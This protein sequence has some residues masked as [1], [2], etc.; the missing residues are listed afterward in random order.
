[1]AIN[2]KKS[3]I[4]RSIF[5]NS[6]SQ[7]MDTDYQNIL[8]N[9]TF[10]YT[11]IRNLFQESGGDFSKKSN[12]KGIQ[13][14]YGDLLINKIRYPFYV[15]YLKNSGEPKNSNKRVQ[16]YSSIPNFYKDSDYYGL[17]IYPTGDDEVI[18]LN[19]FTKFAINKINQ[20]SKNFSSLWINFENISKSY[21][22][23][24][25]VKQEDEDK[26]SYIFRKSNFNHFDTALKM[27]LELNNPISTTSAEE[28]QSPPE[29]ILVN[30]EKLPRNPLLREKVIKLANYTC[31]LCLK[32]DTFKTKDREFY[33]E[34]HHLIP[35]NVTNQKLFKYSLDHLSNLVCLCPECHRKVHFSELKEQ[36][37]ALT[38]LIK[39]RP[40]LSKI[41]NVKSDKELILF[42]DSR[43][44][45]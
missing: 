2:S 6:I 26:V 42:Y 41:Y 20:K 10:R 44:S 43:E 7:L 28:L 15:S 21:F 39:K 25:I 34:A 19:K 23:K 38:H 9:F 14:F 35:F 11:E 18:A 36:I 17:A 22:K 12:L 1:M 3:K 4:Y 8:E 16:V 33:F 45:E 31:E 30:Q 40:N 32:R 13:G 5:N 29:T 37:D 27:L 24:I